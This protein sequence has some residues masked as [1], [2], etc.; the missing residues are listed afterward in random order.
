RGARRVPGDVAMTAAS[1]ATQALER[2]WETPGPLAFRL[3]AVD[4]RRS[5]MR[6]MATAYVFFLLGGFAAL[7]MRAQL[8]QPNLLLVSAEV[9]NQLFSMHGTTMIFFF[10]TPMLSGF[11]NYCI[12]LMI[13]ARDIAFPRLNAFGYWVFLA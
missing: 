1:A 12:P 9:F 3:A 7:V 2:I 11:G 5:C 10:S 6:Y 4:H 8:T 13:G